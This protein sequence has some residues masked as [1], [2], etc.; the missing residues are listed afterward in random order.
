VVAILCATEK[1][2]QRGGKKGRAAS[3]LFDKS[4]DYAASQFGGE[5]DSK[6]IEGNSRSEWAVDRIL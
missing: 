6:G 5:R 3:E 1:A 2:G 4:R